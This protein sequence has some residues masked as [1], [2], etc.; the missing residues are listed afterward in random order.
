MFVV[1]LGQLFGLIFFANTFGKNLVVDITTI[2]ITISETP[3]INQ[4][5]SNR[6]IIHH[7]STS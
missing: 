2:L 5:G 3:F 6:F 4:T 7:G 1:E